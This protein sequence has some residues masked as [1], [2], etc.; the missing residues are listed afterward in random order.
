MARKVFK[1]NLSSKSIEQLQKDL[2]K[3]NDNLIDKCK[4]LSQKLADKGINVAKSK[5]YDSP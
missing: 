2:K 5:I 4:E 3:Y 1:A